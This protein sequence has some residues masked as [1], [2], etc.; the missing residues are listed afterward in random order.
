L[1]KRG[2]TSPLFTNFLNLKYFL[3]LYIGGFIAIISYVLYSMDPENL[4]FGVLPNLV[5]FL[6][7]APIIFLGLKKIYT[8]FNRMFEIG[9]IKTNE[10]RKEAGFPQS[11]VTYLFS[12]K[13]KFERFKVYVTNILENQNEKYIALAI[14][15]GLG[16][17]IIIVSNLQRGYIQGILTSPFSIASLTVYYWVFYWCFIYALFLSV[18][19][20]IITILRALHKINKEKPNLHITQTI[21]ELRV[22][23]SQQSLKKTQIELLD[24]SFRRFKAGLTPLVNFAVSSSLLF[25]LIGSV[26]SAWAVIY[27]ILTKNIDIVWYGTSFAWFS[28]GITFF[29]LGQFD[30][31]QLWSG[32]KKDALELLNFLCVKKTDIAATGP[33][34]KSIEEKTSDFE[35]IG[36]FSENIT[37]LDSVM[38][39]SS[40]I[41]KVAAVYALAFGPIIV[42]EI[43]KMVLM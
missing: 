34:S 20:M 28:I 33:L 24:V 9:Q 10:W 32:A 5:I 18:C 31:W 43:I 42:D 26:F 19:W 41:Y 17:P 21:N 35:L 27:F 11:D 39:T 15:Y 29:I 30:A 1:A 4:H 16:I 23:C 6:I 8:D 37:Q 2:L 36:K 22:S 38:Y 25:A 3:F 14:T 12:D 40:S 13:A 7:L